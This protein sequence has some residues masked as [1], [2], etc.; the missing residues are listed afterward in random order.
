LPSSRAKFSR[1]SLRLVLW[2][3]TV[4]GPLTWLVGG[5]SNLPGRTE[6]ALV[7]PGGVTQTALSDEYKRTSFRLQLMVYA[8]DELAPL[9][10]PPRDWWEELL[11]GRQPVVLP[12]AGTPAS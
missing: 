12:W 1:E 9:H 10:R 6:A 4:I 8:H 2:L 11:S 3:S 7:T 5:T